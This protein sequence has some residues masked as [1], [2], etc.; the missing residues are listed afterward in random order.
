MCQ[1]QWQDI[2]LPF[3]KKVKITHVYDLLYVRLRFS[4]FKYI[5]CKLANICIPSNIDRNN[6]DNAVE[7]I[8]NYVS[9][10]L[11]DVKKSDNEVHLYYNDAYLNNFINNVILFHLLSN[12]RK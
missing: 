1:I 10:K 2:F 9:K 4:A 7:H 3:T 5:K 6:Y 12:G 8:R 11:F